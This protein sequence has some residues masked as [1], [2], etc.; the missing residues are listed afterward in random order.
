MMTAG[1]SAQ[2]I[3][4][5][6]AVEIIRIGHPV[7]RSGTRNVPL[8]MIG[9]PVLDEFVHTMRRTLAGKGVGLAAPQIAVPL[10]LFVIE[11]P[12][13]RVN[14]L[15]VE[16]RNQRERMAFPFEAVINPTWRATSPEMVIFPEGCLSIP[17][18]LADVPRYRSI[19]VD[20][21]TQDGSQKI[22]RLTGWP[23]RIFQ[24]EIDHLDGRLFVDCMLPRTLTSL[25]DPG[26]GV[27]AELLSRLGLGSPGT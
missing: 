18:L 21:W 16:E 27:A 9:T 22:W 2:P 7:L 15:A 6:S 24:H 19:E 17:G 4:E 12:V 10:R 14:A 11:D 25:E 20:G 3:S 13:E 5:G 23:A 26:T 8:D 1:M